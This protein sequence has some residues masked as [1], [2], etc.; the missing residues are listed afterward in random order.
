MA[1]R[2]SPGARI[3]LAA[4]LIS[5]FPAVC[6]AVGPRGGPMGAVLRLAGGGR[7]ILGAL[8]SDK[9]KVGKHRAVQ[10]T[11]D[12]RAPWKLQRQAQLAREPQAGQM[13]L[14]PDGTR[15]PSRDIRVRK[16]KRKRYSRH[17]RNQRVRSGTEKAQAQEAKLRARG[18]K[19]AAAAA[20]KMAAAGGGGAAGPPAPTAVA[21]DAKMSD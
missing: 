3:I 14:N 17:E 21:A 2:R 5:V 6:S 13:A 1:L 7:G 8:R 18:Q 19:R 10:P 9:R 12:G 20:A 4:M 11:K 16:A 15:P